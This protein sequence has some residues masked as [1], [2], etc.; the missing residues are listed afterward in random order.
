MID[1]EKEL[2]RIGKHYISDSYRWEEDIESLA[3]RL[4]DERDKAIE[5]CVKL[6]HKWEKTL[7]ARKWVSQQ[8]EGK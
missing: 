6:A 4:S 7:K 1:V 2:K 5:L 3:R 8:L